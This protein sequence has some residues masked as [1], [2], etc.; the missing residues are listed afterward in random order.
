MLNNLPNI[1]EP[2][3]QSEPASRYPNSYPKY[4]PLTSRR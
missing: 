3:A 1:T 4:V 2:A